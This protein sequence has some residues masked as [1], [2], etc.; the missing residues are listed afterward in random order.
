MRW[1]ALCILTSLAATCSL[2]IQAE[3]DSSQTV[4]GFD[5]VW[6]AAVLYENEENPTIQSFSLVGRYHGQAWNVNADQGNAQDWGNRREIVG[7]KS[8]WFQ[9]FTLEAQMYLNTS[10]CPLY[11]GLYVA[12]I[13]WS[14]PKTDLSV[15]VGRLDYL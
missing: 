8:R 3:A 10:D 4:S 15:S 7:F 12:Y 14:S 2:N 5:K 9:Q 13:E 11:D 6:D 1:P